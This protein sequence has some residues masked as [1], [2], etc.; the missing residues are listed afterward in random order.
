MDEKHFKILE[1]LSKQTRPIKEQEF[2][3]EIT[4]EYKKYTVD[5]G[6]L[7]YELN[8]ILSQNKKWIIEDKTKNYHFSISDTGRIALKIETDKIFFIN[9]Q[10]QI[11]KETKWYERENAK[12]VFD[13]YPNIKRQSNITFWIAFITAIVVVIELILKFVNKHSG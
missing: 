13:N 9:Q 4:S 2:P 3:P 12:N 10:N 11:T 5:N 1:F 8:I 7:F 6:S